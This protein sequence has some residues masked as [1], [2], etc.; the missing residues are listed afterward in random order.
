MKYAFI[1]ILL[2]FSGCHIFESSE[3][4]NIDPDLL[5][6]W[7]MVD[8]VSSSGISPS[9]VSV[10]G[11][12]ISSGGEM[13]KLGVVDSTGSIAVMA[14]SYQPN[15]LQAKNGKMIIKYWAHPILSETEVE[16]R[17]TSNQLIIENESGHFN[18]TFNKTKVGNKIISPMPS[19]L[20]VKI[21]DTEAKNIKVANRIPTAYVNKTSESDLMLSA[22]LGR[23]SI[24]INIDNYTGPGI[25]TIGKGQAEYQISGS[26][27]IQ[28]F[29]TFLDTSGTISIDC[30]PNA[31]RCSGEFEF[32][33]DDPENDVDTE[34]ILEDGSFN[35]PLLD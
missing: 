26:D 13:N 12:S 17:I 35:V 9:N 34:P 31:S 32:S 29:Q 5:G 22:S 27:W 23:K 25:Y 7:Y 30:D 28:L 2:I 1:L 16:Y 8:T 10:R 4:E 11:W 20:Q 14:S 3:T 33:T 6:H 15:I 21:D 19:N 24:M 18:G